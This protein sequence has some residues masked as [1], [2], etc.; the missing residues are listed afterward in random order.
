M[1]CTLF[2]GISEWH[3]MQQGILFLLQARRAKESF[4]RM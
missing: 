1:T 4:E 3:K 2:G